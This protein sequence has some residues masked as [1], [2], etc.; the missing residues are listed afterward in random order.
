MDLCFQDK[1][2]DRA[3][4]ESIYERLNATRKDWLTKMENVEKAEKI[5]ILIEF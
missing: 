4:S 2:D 5:N 1:A 3:N